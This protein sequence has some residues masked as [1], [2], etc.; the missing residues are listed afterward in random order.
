MHG[1]S[2]T[3]SS[4]NGYWINGEFEISTDPARIDL[5][6][7]HGFLTSSYWAKGIPAETVQR[8][9]QNSLCFGVYCGQQQVGFARIITD[10]ATFSYLADVFILE[11]YRGRGLSKWLM[12]CIMAHPQLQGLRRWIL[13]TR[14]AHGLYRQF[15]FDVLKNPQRWMERH[16]PDVYAEGTGRATEPQPRNTE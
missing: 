7:V 12:E 16:N 8:S 9:I 15:G 3:G 13:A 10:G 4:V 11:P 2:I 14:D 5:A 1:S 6:L